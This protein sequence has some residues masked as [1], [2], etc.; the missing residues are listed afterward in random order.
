MHPTFLKLR[1]IDGRAAGIDGVD[2]SVVQIDADNAMA[3][4]GE[5]CRKGAPNLPS[6]T[7]ETDFITAPNQTQDDP[8]HLA[9]DVD[10]RARR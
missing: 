8:S 6:P 10:C 7:T 9:S 4:V 3:F 1:F 5:H 2:K